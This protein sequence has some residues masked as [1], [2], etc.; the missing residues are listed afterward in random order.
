MA[1]TGIKRFLVIPKR[2]G[3]RG[4]YDEAKSLAR[5]GADA[6]KQGSDAASKAAQQ[7]K[8]DASSA[9]DD[10]RIVTMHYYITQLYIYIHKWSRSQI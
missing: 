8:H 9:A 3:S 4:L 7:I 10:V 2:Y 5:K 6:A 1:S